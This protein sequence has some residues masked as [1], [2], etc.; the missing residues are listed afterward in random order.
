[1]PTDSLDFFST[2]ASTEESEEREVDEAEWRGES[3][4]DW[5]AVP[6]AETSDSTVVEVVVRLM[7]FFSWAMPDV[8]DLVEGILQKDAGFPR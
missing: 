6:G 7:G 1:M 8:V 3:I 5:T 4:G 2:A